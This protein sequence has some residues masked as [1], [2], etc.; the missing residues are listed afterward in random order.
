MKLPDGSYTILP[1]HH[2]EK[3]LQ[4]IVN[5]SPSKSQNPIGVLTAEHRDTWYKARERLM[6]GIDLVYC[7]LI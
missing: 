6:K 7:C 1:V 3:E 4:Q 2:I 5:S